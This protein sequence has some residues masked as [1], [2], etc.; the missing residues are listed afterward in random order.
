MDIVGINIVAVF[1]IIADYTD[2]QWGCD[3][4]GSNDKIPMIKSIVK[5]DLVLLRV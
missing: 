2:F 3:S 5:L 4:V 1:Y